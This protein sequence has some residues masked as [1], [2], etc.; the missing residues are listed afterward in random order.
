MTNTQAQ[1]V[2]PVDAFLKVAPKQPFS[3]VGTIAANQSG[4][5]LS[6]VVWQDD[7]PVQAAFITAIEYWVQMEVALTLP[8]SAS[9]TVS[10][11]A[12]ACALSQQLGIG[13]TSP[14]PM[15]E[16]TPFQL[17][18][19]SQK[20]NF[21]PLYPGLGDNSGFFANVIDEGPWTNVVGG[22]GSLTPGETVTNS[23]TAA[24]TTNYTFNFKV[25]QQLQRRRHLL[26]GAV[27]LGDVANRITNKV[28][29]NP[30]VGINP[31][32]NLFVNASANVTATLATQATVTAVYETRYIDL[33]YPGMPASPSPTVTMGLQVVRNSKS[34]FNMGTVSHQLH[35]TSMLF[36]AI[37]HI[38]VNGELPLQLDYFGDWD[39]EIQA[40]ARVAYDGQQNTFG[41]YFSDYHDRYQR[42]PYKGHYVFDYERG[43][44][45]PLTS[46]T[47]YVGWRTNTAMYAQIFGIPL[48]PA[49][50]TAWRFPSGT[51]A[52][53]PYVTMYDFGLKEVPY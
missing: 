27:P 11:F 48:T 21:D 2:N 44:Y 30:L 12:P 26:W 9:A 24:T 1:T 25:R 8:A 7:L 36:T 46:V 22:A 16:L 35:D 52:S 50:S 53:N 32:L 51:T 41:A 4:G 49:M 47:P 38:A 13:G 6:N 17:D 39:T 42:Y 20:I 15:M 45:P 31:E 28:Q 18:W 34:G 33:A 10:P 5:S 14:W 19:E 29:L 23:G 43:D 40:N 3:I 37:H